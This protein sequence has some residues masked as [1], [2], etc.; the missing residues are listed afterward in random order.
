MK[1]YSKYVI[2]FVSA[3][4]AYFISDFLIIQLSK[5]PNGTNTDFGYIKIGIILIIAVI[6][7]CTSLIIFTISSNNKRN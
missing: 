4:F 3:L 6:I 5:S 7:G 2:S 1:S